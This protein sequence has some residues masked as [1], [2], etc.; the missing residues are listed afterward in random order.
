MKP[1]PGLYNEII[2][3]HALFNKIRHLATYTLLSTITVAKP[4]FYHFGAGL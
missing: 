1:K 4:W 2:F 3:Y